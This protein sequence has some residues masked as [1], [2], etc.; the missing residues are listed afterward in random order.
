[1]HLTAL[2][3]RR[4]A[5][6]VRGPA[7]ALL[8]TGILNM[9]LAV[10]D[11]IARIFMLANFGQG[12]APPNLPPFLQEVFNNR[13]AIAIG[14]ATDA[15]GIVLAILIMVGSVRMRR[16]ES[17]GMSVAASVISMLPCVTACCC[18]GIPFGIWSLIVLNR[19]EVRSCFH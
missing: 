16:L 11:L 8:V 6:A 18:L 3:P 13:S 10:V 14:I 19:P 2:D 12:Q 7:I 1:V 15:V 4:A 5:D 17:Y 9:A